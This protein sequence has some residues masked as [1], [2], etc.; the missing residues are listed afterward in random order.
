AVPGDPPAVG[1]APVHGVGLEVEDVVVG[2]GRAD[3][4]AGR[5]VHDALRLAGGAAG[6]HQEQQ[7]LAVHGLG[8]AGR[9]VVRLRGR[10]LVVPDV[11]P[12]GDR[13]VPA[14]PPDHQA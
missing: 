4:V 5:G 1:G 7:V 6:V 10:R 2:G 12:V 9:G 14:G 13:D 11:A 3:Q 8:G